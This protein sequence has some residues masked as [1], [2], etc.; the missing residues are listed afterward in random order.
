MAVDI[1]GPL[2]ITRHGN[3]YIMVVGDYFTKWKE[4]FAIPNHTALT[5]ADKL[6]SEVFCR[7]GCPLQL[8]TD[9][10]REFE[11]NLFAEICNLLGID[12]T[13][14]T[15]DRP[16][17]DGLVER[18][19]RTLKQMLAIYVEQEPLDWDDH[20]PYILL[21][22]RSSEHKSTHCSPNL[23]MLGRE[24]RVPIDVMVENPSGNQTPECP[25]AYVR[26]LQ[27]NMQKIFSSLL[28]SW[29]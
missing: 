6:V 27:E 11:S 29:E 28:T 1:V 7:F 10:G 22:Y 9:Q 4:A 26:W 18:F 21:A 24:V 25:I 19:N 8:H 23:M 17:S 20:L 3:E 2:P 15:P 12:K 16:Q 13:R 14:T 5:V